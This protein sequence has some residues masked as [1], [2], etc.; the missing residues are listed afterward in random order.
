MP[1][2]AMTAEMG[3]L[4]EEIAQEVAKTL[5]LAVMRD[6]VVEHVAEKMRVRRSLISKMRVGKAGFLERLGTDEQSIEIYTAEEIFE[7]ANKGNVILIGWGAAYMLRTV[8]HVICVRICR[9]VNER[10]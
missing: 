4:R 10:V 2:I 3:S 9:S 8:P 7:L 1:V 6:E 5:N